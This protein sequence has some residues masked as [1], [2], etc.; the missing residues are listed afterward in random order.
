MVDFDG[1]YLLL[2][3]C[4][5]GIWFKGTCGCVFTWFCLVLVYLNGGYL[6]CLFIF[7][8][9]FAINSVAIVF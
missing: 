4:F 7:F 2:G 6:W 9:C 5:L 3:V 1:C 8:L